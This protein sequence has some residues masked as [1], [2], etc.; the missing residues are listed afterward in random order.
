MAAKNKPY[1]QFGPYILFKKLESDS[2]SELWRAARIENGQLG[3]LVGLRRF[4]GGN[5]EA[6]AASAATAKQIVAGLSGTSFAKNQV[7]DTINGVPFI[8]LDYSGGRSLRHIVDRA[9]GGNGLTPNPIPIDQAIVI[10]EKVALS[11]ATT[12]D[13]KFGGD[14]LSHG[15]LIPQF[16]WISDDGEIRVAGQQLGAGIMASLKDAR[17]ASE[18]GR[19]FAPEYHASSQPTKSSEV[20]SMGALLYLLVT[21]AEP[22]DPINGSAFTSAIKGAKTMTGT[23]VPDDIRAILDKSLTIEAGPRYGTM[24]DMK[25]AISAL[26]HG[27]KYSA[28]T[29]NLAFYMSNLLKKELEGEALDRDREMKVNVAPYLDAPPHP[30]AAPAASSGPMFTSVDQGARPK[31]KAPL[32]IAA[33]LIIAGIG[34]GAFVMMRSKSP[35]QASVNAQK[36]ATAS[37]VSPPKPQLVSQP[38]VATPNP[39]A[40]SSAAPSDDAA[41]KKAFEDAVQLKLQEEMM[42]LQSNYTKSLQQKQSKNAPVQVAS[43]PIPTPAP[44]RDEPSASQLD[45]QRLQTRAESAPLTPAPAVV[46]TQTQAPAVVPAAPAPSTVREGD[47]VEINDLDSTPKRVSSTAPQYP[48]MALRQRV[49][50]TILVTALVSENGDV[51]DVKILRGDKRFGFEEAAVRAVRQT[52]FTAPVKDGKRVKTWFPL[53]VQ[54]KL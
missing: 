2:L 28:T 6:L 21:G 14:R 31:S 43:A 20:Y 49:E 39:G 37:M 36:P 19:Y 18:I 50:T 44:S 25:Q 1:E 16:I 13:L 54:F 8:A 7:I 51:V 47:V 33:T 53:P 35:A 9:R 5:R 4:T 10:A 27:G 52:K 11:L 22:P 41:S 15:A 24:G 40:T 45:Q 46:A 38:L 30:V 26:V 48:I 23:P 32:A 42:K 12:S 29:F 3:S 17:V 34:V